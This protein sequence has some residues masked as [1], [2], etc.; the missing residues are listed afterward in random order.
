VWAYLVEPENRKVWWPE[1]QLDPRLGGAVS[2][3]WSE[4][5][6]GSS[7]TRDASGEIDVWVDGHALG[8]RWSEAGD[9]HSTA[10]LVTLRAIGAETRVTVTET[11]FDALSTPAESAAA[12]Q[13]GWQVLLGDL[14]KAVEAAMAS[15]QFAEPEP[16]IEEP[17]VEETA[18]PLGDATAEIA[19]IVEA[20]DDAAE[21]LVDDASAVESELVPEYE[22]VAEPDVPAE[23]DAAAEVDAELVSDLDVEAEVEDRTEVV[24][25]AEA[26]DVP[27]AVAVVDPSA[28]PEPDEDTEQ[29][30]FD[31]LIRG[32]QAS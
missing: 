21:T 6:D 8:F 27:E 19:V 18:E 5:N 4:T 26:V 12:S 10:V 17:V 2:E 29:P 30:D 9:S 3:R 13:E 7:V 24:T 22:V 15:G 1:L 11:G 16:P 32:P 25:E 28:D 14:V 31:D 23:P 20:P